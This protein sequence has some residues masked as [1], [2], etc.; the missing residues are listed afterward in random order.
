VERALARPELFDASAGPCAQRQRRWRLLFGQLSPTGWCTSFRA[1][2]VKTP[3][4]FLFLLGLG[5]W[6]TV[7]G[8]AARPWRVAIGKGAGQ[9]RPMPWA[10]SAGILA[11]AMTSPVN[12]GLRHVLPVYMGFSIVAALAVVRLAKTGKWFV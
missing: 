7:R 8:R 9:A 12:Y 6:L 3:L 5:A 11:P 1:L 10:F 2:A 4:A